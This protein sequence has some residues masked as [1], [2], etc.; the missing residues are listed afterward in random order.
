[1]HKKTFGIPCGET[2]RKNL[3]KNNL[4]RHLLRTHYLGSHVSSLRTHSFLKYL[5][6]LARQ[7]WSS[8][9][10]AVTAMMLVAVTTVCGASPHGSNYA[11]SHTSTKAV[12]HHRRVESP[13]V[14]FPNA[15]FN[16]AVVSPGI[17]FKLTQNLITQRCSTDT[18][19]FSDYSATH[20][21]A[22]HKCSAS[23]TLFLF[24]LH[25]NCC[26]HLFICSHAYYWPRKSFFLSPR[27]II[28]CRGMST[29]SQVTINILPLVRC[30][31]VSMHSLES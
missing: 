13:N 8:S 15:S 4:I 31:A 9:I 16:N 23:Y 7:R 5:S 25:I 11:N 19:I 28:P 2:A 17:F 1:M 26:T 12:C 24:F 27:T 14:S 30:T 29:C 21:L 3:R 10:T 22:I 6:W 20:C 18:S